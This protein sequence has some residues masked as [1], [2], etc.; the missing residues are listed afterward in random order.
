ML[1]PSASSPRLIP[2]KNTPPGFREVSMC[3]SLRIQ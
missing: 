3:C 2:A 1:H